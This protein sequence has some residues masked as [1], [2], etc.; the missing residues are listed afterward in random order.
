MTHAEATYNDLSGVSAE[1]IDTTKLKNLVKDTSDFT[2]SFAYKNASQSQRDAFDDAYHYAEKII[3]DEFIVSQKEYDKA[4]NTLSKVYKE[5]EVA[6]SKRINE[7]K[8]PLEAEIKEAS[9]VDKASYTEKSY[10]VFKKALVAAQTTA[11]STNSTKEQYQ[12]SLD[13]LKA[14]KDS[15]VK[16]DSEKDKELKALLVKLKESKYDLEV[17]VKA[18]NYLLDTKPKTVQSVK[19]KLEQLLKEANEL[20]KETQQ[21]INEVENV[22]G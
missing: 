11:N 6:E 7:A 12:T 8:E 2:A 22:Q 21:F 16:V 9:K 20:L 10:L 13:A 18:I 5:I 1:E 3:D 19:P 4:Y 14:A 15:L 17:K